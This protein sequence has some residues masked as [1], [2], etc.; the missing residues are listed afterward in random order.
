MNQNNEDNWKLSKRVTHYNQP[1]FKMKRTG[2]DE[3]ITHLS[4]KGI[5]QTLDMN[6][7]DLGINYEF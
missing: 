4:K 2:K 5:V 3:L 6:L 7:R 1:I